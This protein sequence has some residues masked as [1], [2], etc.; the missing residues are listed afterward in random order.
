MTLPPRSAGVIRRALRNAGL[1]STDAGEVRIWADVTITEQSDGLV[2]TETGRTRTPTGEYDSSTATRWTFAGDSIT[3]EHLRYGPARP[4][5]LVTLTE[6]ADGAWVSGEPHRCGH[7]RY[8]AEVRMLD[9]SVRLAWSV[10]GPSKSLRI[11]TVYS[12]RQLFGSS[13]AVAR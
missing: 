7:D 12:P 8:H 13:V 10:Q 5:L 4:V 9:D 11:R 3:I 1:S 6:N 2:L